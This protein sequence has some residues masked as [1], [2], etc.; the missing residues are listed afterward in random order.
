MASE[1]RAG[2]DHNLLNM[3]NL[4]ESVL[5]RLA[6]AIMQKHSVDYPAALAI[7]NSFKLNLVCDDRLTES[8]AL[9][10]AL[11][12]AVNTG[13]RAFL[14]GVFVNMPPAIPCLLPWPGGR[15]LN[16]IVQFLGGKSLGREDGPLTQTLFLGGVPDVSED[17]LAIVCSGWRGGIIPVGVSCSLSS[18]H[19]FALGGIL[20]GALGVARGFLRVSGLSS[21]PIEEPQGFS[22]W[23]PDLHWLS[24]EAD[25]PELE[26]LPKRLWM[27]GLGHLGQ[28]YLWSFGLL[29]YAAPGDA[30]FLLQ[31]FDSAIRGNYTSGLLCEEHNLDKHKTRICAEWLEERGFRTTI[32]ERAFDSFTKRTGE[33]PFVACCGF[34]AAEPRRILAGAGFDLIV[35]CALGAET[36]RFDRAIIHTFP[37]ASRK[38]EEIWASAREEAVD[39]NIV[40]AFNRDGD[41]GIIAETLARKAVSSSFVGAFA[42]AFVCAEILRALHGGVRCEL[43]QVQLRHSA[44]PGVIVK[45]ENY[46]NR[47]AR[48]GYTAARLVQR[49]AA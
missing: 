38:P 43:V 34:D 19:D 49:M 45:P 7:L 12:T 41:C 24:S 13:K 18:S 28:A 33:E 25:G 22:L 14:G 35:E 26:L 30:L 39:P 10:A 27:L 21:R 5:N 2:P 15:T 6:K 48:S 46:S 11:L 17:G 44:P 1:V 31:D 16:Q 20:A 8:S 23:R 36:S 42:G 9:Q 40:R 4:T 32:T 47:V 37:D 29:P 3:K